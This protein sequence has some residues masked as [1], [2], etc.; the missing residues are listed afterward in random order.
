MSFQDQCLLFSLSSLEKNFSTSYDHSGSKTS[1]SNF[2]ACFSVL[3]KSYSSLLQFIQTRQRRTSVEDPGFSAIFPEGLSVSPNNGLMLREAASVGKTLICLEATRR[4]GP[5]PSPNFLLLFANLLHLIFHRLLWTV[6]INTG[7]ILKSI[8]PK[9]WFRWFPETADKF[10]FSAERSTENV[11]TINS[12]T[13]RLQ[14]M[15]PL[16]LFCSWKYPAIVLVFN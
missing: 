7:Q 4:L 11:K 16:L 10:E 3:F 8:H 2:L 6:S 12:M 14:E 15:E 5:S 1:S 9:S 13:K